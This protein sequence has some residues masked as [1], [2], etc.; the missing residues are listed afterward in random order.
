MRNNKKKM[1]KK[2]LIVNGLVLILIFVVAMIIAMGK[3]HSNATGNTTITSQIVEVQVGRQTIEKT[4]TSSGQI[5]SSGT[6]KLSLST[7]K[8]FKTMCVEE[9]DIVKQGNPILQYTDGTYLTASYDC[10]V[11]SYTLPEIGSKA[12]SSHFI[13]IENMQTLTM[14]LSIQESEINEVTVGQSVAITL[15]AYE[16]KTYTGTITKI[17]ATG[18]Y[19]SSG[20]T[21]TAIVSFENDGNVKLGM[22][23][24]CSILLEKAEN[25][26]A[27]PIEAIQT[28]DD[29]KYVIV[30][31][32]NGQTQN[33]QVETG[34]SNDSYVQILSDLEENQTIQMV[35]TTSNVTFGLGSSNASSSNNGGFDRQSMRESGSS[36]EMPGGEMPGRN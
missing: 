7:T 10:V 13:M 27:V 24:S 25:V 19:A 17:N 1:G 29:Q 4:L 14:N 3:N 31:K 20:S 15:S 9:D 6:E 11:D 12:T 33:I 35:Q 30:V 21:F 28:Q 26:I 16:D 5:T 32:E 36:L 34:I 2:A 23:A 22:S 18:T 8:Y